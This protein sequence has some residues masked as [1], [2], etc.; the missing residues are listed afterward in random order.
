MSIKMLQK[1]KHNGV[2]YDIGDE[3]T[4]ITKEEADRLVELKAAEV[5]DDKFKESPGKIKN[6]I[7][8]QKRANRKREEE[9]I[10]A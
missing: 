8:S 3:V 9:L 2:I 4:D 7:L 5:I 1:V 10:Y 6:K